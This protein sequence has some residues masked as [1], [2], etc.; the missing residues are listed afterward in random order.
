MRGA[1]LTFDDVTIGR[2]GAPAV[3]APISTPLQSASLHYPPRARHISLASG[4][5]ERLGNQVNIITALL[6]H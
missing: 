3:V 1:L 4:M 2:A 6:H 5:Y